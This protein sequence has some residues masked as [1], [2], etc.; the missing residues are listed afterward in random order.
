M[1]N[2]IL[3]GVLSIQKEVN[4]KVLTFVAIYEKPADYPDGYIA[5]VWIVLQGVSIP[6]EWEE[7]RDTYEE[8]QGIMPDF[9]QN[10]GRMPNDD[11]CVKEVWI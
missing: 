5:R 3:Q 9:L 4:K 1:D 10:I 7:R 11:P 6:T 2:K 8:I